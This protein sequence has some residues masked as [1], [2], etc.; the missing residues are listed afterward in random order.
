MENC[1][2]FSC[3]FL[4]FQ[5]CG[6]QPIP[7]SK[8][9][10]VFQKTLKCWSVFHLLLITIGMASM[11]VYRNT[12]FFSKDMVGMI[13]DIIVFVG[14]VGGHFIII[15]ESL[16]KM[17]YFNKIA[18]LL[19]RSSGLFEH[20][21]VDMSVRDAQF[22]RQYSLKLFCYLSYM[23]TA[24][25]FTIISV[26]DNDIQWERFWYANISSLVVSRI[27]HMQHI[28]FTDL[29]TSRFEILNDLLFNLSKHDSDL[30]FKYRPRKN[31]ELLKKLTVLKKC[32]NLI[33]RLTI[34]MNA[35]FCWSQLANL[36]QNFL[37]IISELYWVFYFMQRSTAT[38]TFWGRN[39]KF[40]PR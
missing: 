19:S 3:V 39:Q 29:V 15:A 13:N 37:E 6:I 10:Q 36:A 17:N 18:S 1:L 20:L 12:M 31:G 22:L 30:A 28:F 27:R 23:I 34:H 21:G 40:Y 9:T 8:G 24:E 7:S 14:T 35:L 5:I 38:T 16:I 25:L 11:F 33:W 2:R 32:H 4:V 26:T